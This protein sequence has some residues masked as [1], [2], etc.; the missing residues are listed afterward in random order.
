VWVNLKE[1]RTS[2]L[3][4]ALGDLKANNKAWECAAS[5]FRGV[6]VLSRRNY[7]CV[8]MCWIFKLYAWK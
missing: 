8:V 2:R 6:V 7:C 5:Q 4:Y 3:L 1:V